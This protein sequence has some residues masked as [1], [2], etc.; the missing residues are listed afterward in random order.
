MAYRMS[1]KSS[2]HS[3]N[4]RNSKNFKRNNTMSIERKKMPLFHAEE[5]YLKNG[6][7]V[8][9]IKKLSQAVSITVLYK[10]GTADDPEGL[11]GLSHFL[12]HMMFRGTKKYPGN[13]FKEKIAS[14]GGYV[15]AFT[16]FDV[17]CYENRIPQ[18]ALEEVLE[19]EA[20]RM[21]NLQY[22]Q[23]D[24]KAELKAVEEEYGMRMGNSPF[25][26]VTELIYRNLYLYHPYGVLPIGYPQHIKSYTRENAFAWYQ[27]WY[28]PNNAVLTIAGDID[29]EQTKHCIEKHFGA[30]P[31]HS[32]PERIRVKEPEIKSTTRYIKQSHDRFAFT[33]V[34]FIFDAPNKDDVYEFAVY[35]LGGG[36]LSLFYNHFVRKLNQGVQ[37]VGMSYSLSLDSPNNMSLMFEVAPDQVIQTS[38]FDAFEEY[39][40]ELLSG[41]FSSEDFQ[42]RFE[43]AKRRKIANLILKTDGTMSAAET[44]I[45]LGF[46]LSFDE[47]NHRAQVIEKITLED[48][49][50]AIVDILM[51]K[52]KVVFVGVPKNENSHLYSFK[53]D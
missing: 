7:H 30:L 17:T 6:L 32:L 18:E 46:N 16:S 19:M 26:P 10:V 11:T 4:S 40:K 45:N 36:T 29:F 43:S 2:M 53:V 35:L 14:M 22:N 13:I 25:G 38:V 9:L 12:E 48:V 8:V 15:N 3:I 47:I 34:E 52:P 27:K 44:F 20:D 42:N 21:V 41:Y 39:K 49:K 5:F 1:P 50:K 33:V 28:H 37:D 51:K 24:V 31:S 23:D